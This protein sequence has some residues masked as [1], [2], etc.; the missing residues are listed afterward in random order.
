VANME[1][2][3][4]HIRNTKQQICFMEMF[5]FP[6]SKNCLTSKDLLSAYEVDFFFDH[7]SREESKPPWKFSTGRAEFRNLK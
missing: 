6:I 3:K 7:S 2:I 4:A 5:S 1:K